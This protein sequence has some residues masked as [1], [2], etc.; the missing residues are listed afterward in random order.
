M[1]DCNTKI[2]LSTYITHINI[3]ENINTFKQGGIRSLN[4][5]N[6]FMNDLSGLLKNSNIVERIGDFFP[7][8]LCYTD[9]LRLKGLSTASMQ[10]LLG[11]CSLTY[12]ANNFFHYVSYLAH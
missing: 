5:P 4:L 8:H 11:I 12:N 6:D 3:A 2:I 10:K 9:D 7:N 1:P